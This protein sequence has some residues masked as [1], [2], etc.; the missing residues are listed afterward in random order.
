[1]PTSGAT[2]R[3]LVYGLAISGQAVATALVRRGYDVV[4]ADDEA[5][6][7]KRSFAESIGTELVASPDE[8]TIRRLVDAAD[9]VAPAP[10]VAESHPLIVAALAN[11]TPLRTEIDLAGEWEEQ[12]PGGRRPLLAVTGTD[13]KTTTTLLATEMLRAAGI[14]AAAVGNTEVPLVAAL[15]DPTVDAFVVECT[16][17]RLSWTTCFRPDSAVWL[18]LAPDHLN[19]H[20][21]LDSYIA[22]KARMW[23]FQGP[24]DAAIGFIDDPVVMRHLAEAP[25][26]RVTFGLNGADYFFATAAASTMDGAAASP[27]RSAL[28]GPDGAICDVT[29]M[30]RAL[31]HDITNALAAA[32]L[33][34]EA[35]LADT[36]E[37]AAAVRTFV[38]PP[39]RLELVG[40]VNGVAWYNDSKATTPHAALTAI[41]AFD[42]LV[43]I[44]GGRNKGLDLGSLASE[45][46]RMR[47]VV[48]IGESAD[49]IASVFGGICPV[50]RAESMAAAVAAAGEL[51]RRGDAV[52]LSPA[53]AS[54]DWYPVGGYPARGDDFRS[55]VS[56]HLGSERARCTP[57][58]QTP[59]DHEQRPNGGAR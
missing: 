38:G 44:A 50:R 12:R 13:G 51:A 47:G 45:P 53:C 42:S 15:D 52:V 26:R 32:A 56:A 16:S 46:H 9:L 6:D 11:G 20:A 30:R 19:W 14:N 35:G 24:D 31:P 41:R 17:F 29:E 8:D 23:M 40:D 21:D 5:T 58:D 54:F 37:I 1:M 22:A 33:V 48:A 57:V 39:H 43:L 3:A 28:M 7:A 49:L 27:G 2:G 55:L 25:G 36:A 34:R 59:L 10:G 4:V 18:N